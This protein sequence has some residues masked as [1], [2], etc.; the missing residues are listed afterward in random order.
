MSS[1]SAK[2][3]VCVLS[4]LDP[5]TSDRL[6]IFKGGITKTKKHSFP[7]KKMLAFLFFQSLTFV[8]KVDDLVQKESPKSPPQISLPR[9]GCLMCG[10]F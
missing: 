1:R 2:L 6:R 10:R 7:G 4:P 3:V 9:C 5:Q 8:L